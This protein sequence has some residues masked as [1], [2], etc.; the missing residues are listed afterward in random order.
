MASDEQQIAAYVDA[1]YTS[2]VKRT[3]HWPFAWG[4]AIY[5]DGE[6]AYGEKNIE[7][8]RAAQKDAD[9]LIYRTLNGLPTT[10]TL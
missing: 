4:F 9:D 2:V 5:K 7:S 6:F 8:R 1:G 3:G 10:V